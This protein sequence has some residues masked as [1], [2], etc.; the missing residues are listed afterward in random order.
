ML[1]SLIELHSKPNNTE[2]SDKSKPHTFALE[3]I[4]PNPTTISEEAIRSSLRAL[5]QS[6]C[7]YKSSKKI[8]IESITV[9]NA[10]KVKIRIIMKYL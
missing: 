8:I 1:Y 9:K 4:F 2:E 7:C 5:V 6:K 10:Y 3:R